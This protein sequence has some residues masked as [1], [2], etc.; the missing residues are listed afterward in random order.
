MGCAAAVTP[1]RLFNALA[2][3]SVLS[4]A[5]LRCLHAE[6]PWEPVHLTVI[7]L[8][9]CVGLL[10]LA[11]HP[12]ARSGS[13]GALAASLPG[14]VIAGAALKLA[15]PVDTWPMFSLVPFVAGGALAVAA[16]LSL[17]RSFAI[18]PALRRIVRRGPY[19]IVRHPAYLGELLMVAACCAAHGR[20]EF[21]PLWPLAAA[22]PFVVVRIVA[23]ERTLVHAPEYSAYRREVNWRLMPMVW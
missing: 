16:F 5:V 15:P 12:A 21:A 2:G 11:R 19:R 3:A 10:L 17:G 18:L 8:N 6:S 14:L 1:Q 23:E 20:I 7:A 4:W 13:T 22:V 9:A